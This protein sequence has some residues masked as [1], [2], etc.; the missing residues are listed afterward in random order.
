M[1][2][3]TL[4]ATL[5]MLPRAA[6]ADEGIRVFVVIVANNGSYDGT[7]PPLRFADDD[8][9]R[10]REL[11]RLYTED[12]ELFT[13]M[14]AD[15]QQTFADAVPNAKLPRRSELFEG[16]Q[17]TF[18]KI[19]A[20][21]ASGAR[22]AF[23]FIYSGHGDV[24]DGV[25]FVHLL[26]GP[27]TRQDLYAKVIEA[28]PADVNHVVVDACNAYFMVASRGKGAKPAGDYAGLVKTLVSRETLDAH[29]NT[30][31]VLATTTA[32]EVHEWSR[33]E[34][35]VFSHELRTAMSGAADAN[36]DGAVSYDEVAAFLAAANGGVPDPK[37]RVQALT[38]PPRQ[39]LAEPFV[40]VTTQG[41]AAV[42]PK[43]WK[44]RF[45]VEDDRRVRFAD[46][47]KAAG[48]D[49]TLHLVPR[50]TY[51]VRAGDREYRLGQT[52]A[53]TSHDLGSTPADP[54]SVAA[55]GSAEDQLDAHLFAVP[56]DGEYARGFAQAR[57]LSDDP[58]AVT[59]DAPA[60]PPAD[61][62]A[63]WKI[64]AFAVAGST[65]IA[66]TVLE[67]MARHDAELYRD[68]AGSRE[69]VR[70]HRERADA[71]HDAAVV[72]GAVA[73]GALLSAGGMYLYQWLAED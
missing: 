41:S 55:R 42:F 23:Y 53:G 71:Q 46:L 36:G 13:V 61:R 27:L 37:A 35:G 1:R 57:A 63:P 58:L 4:I 38:R 40:R 20:A 47:N 62:L 67:M 44:G 24:R 73:G 6:F 54:I 22:T 70:A 21:R 3:A 10:Y 69:D 32:A 11:F 31:V 52:N 15:T 16:L 49:L 60:P 19:R 64:G 28:S 50:P 17:R 33:V 34:A 56:Y 14:D 65:A 39:N 72:L 2:L 26:D 51:Y 30:G 7:R 5:A 12:V 68:S 25:G 43:E 29:P 9:V 8:G 45:Y 18:D 59:L 48:Q 66:A